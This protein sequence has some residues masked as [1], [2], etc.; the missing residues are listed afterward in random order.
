[1]KPSLLFISLALAL[2]LGGCQRPGQNVYN[3]NEVGRSS[4]IN[5]ATILAVR[6]VSIRGKNTG[7]GA[8]V[9][10]AAGGIA[11]SGM[12]RG[13]GR[14]GAVLA[15]AVVGGVIG[16]LAE[17]A[18]ADR[19]ALE[20]TLI[21]ESGVTMTVVQDRNQGER[22]FKPGDRV[23]LQ[24]SGGTQRVLPADHIPSRIKRPVGIKV[25]D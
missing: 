24:V 10:A 20:Y 21:L 14:V 25:Y 5:F 23:M 17:Q 15:G 1:M 16:A 9:G 7:L 13:S 18:A 3:Y 2:V 6:E 22:V 11:G 8:G 12:G 19:M 4:L